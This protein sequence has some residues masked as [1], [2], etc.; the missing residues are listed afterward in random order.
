MWDG[1]VSTRAPLVLAITG[2]VALVIGLAGELA[3]SVVSVGLLMENTVAAQQ[4]TI[5]VITGF[6]LA[7]FAALHYWLPKVTGRAVH[8]GPAKAA[9]GSSS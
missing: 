4:D 6:V 9:P 8:E 3:T 1:A 5:L 7:M 2:A